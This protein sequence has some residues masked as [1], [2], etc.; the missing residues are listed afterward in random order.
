MVGLLGPARGPARLRYAPRARGAA[1]GGP[2]PGARPAPRR[3]APRARGPGS[4]LRSTGARRRQRGALPRRAAR[5]TPH[6]GSVGPGRLPRRLDPTP[7]LGRCAWA[8]WPGCTC[9]L[10]AATSGLAT[11]GGRVPPSRSLDHLARRRGRRRGD[12]SS[13]SARPSRARG[14]AL[15]ALSY[16]PSWDKQESSNEASSPISLC[17]SVARTSELRPV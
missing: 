7:P 9:H 15:L 6:P 4:V 17:A 12:V 13:P 16:H 5:A 11:G 1:A 14:A 8:A 2:S 3:S 10:L